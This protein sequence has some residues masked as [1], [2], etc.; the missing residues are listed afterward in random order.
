MVLIILP[1]LVVFKFP[2]NFKEYLKKYIFSKYSTRN[3]IYAM[4]G[5][6]SA[7]ESMLL[8][9]QR[10]EYGFIDCILIAVIYIFF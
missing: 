5:C 9:N 4:S 10:E 1:F 7:L 6:T 3:D 8:L 2:Y